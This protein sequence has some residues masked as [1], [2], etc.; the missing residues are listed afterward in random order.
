MHFR[1]RREA[2]NCWQGAGF[3]V[4]AK[5]LIVLGVPRGGVVVAY[6]VAR[7]LGAPLDVYITRKIGAPYN[8]ELAIGAVA[9]MAQW[10]W[11]TTSSNASACPTAMYG[12]R[13]HASAER[14]NGAGGVPRSRPRSTCRARRSSWWMMGGH[15]ATILASLRAIKARIRRSSSWLSPSGQRTRFRSC[16]PKRIR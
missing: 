3:A 12:K 5:D 8:P 16:P 15:G 10:C 9:A 7:A 4:R 11:I 13:P 6:E 14:S 1:D 2:A